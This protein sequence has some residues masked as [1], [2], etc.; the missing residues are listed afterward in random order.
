MNKRTKIKKK[1]KEANNKNNQKVKNRNSLI[2]F[3]NQK[4]IKLNP[5]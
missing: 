4:E 3:C 1:G 5:F 2:K